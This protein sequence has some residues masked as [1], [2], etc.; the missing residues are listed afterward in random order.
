MRANGKGCVSYRASSQGAS[1]QG[2]HTR[3]HSKQ[4][5]AAERE[6]QSGS[7]SRS[8]A[9]AVTVKGRHYPCILPQL[10]VFYR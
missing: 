7:D 3:Q 6:W 10:A 4:E 8:A 9:A 2:Q 1:Y 5:S